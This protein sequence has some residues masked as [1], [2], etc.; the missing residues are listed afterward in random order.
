MGS[1]VTALRDHIFFRWHKHIDDLWEYW[2]KKQI[3]ELA[4]DAPPVSLQTSDVVIKK[5]DTPIDGFAE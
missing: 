5:T 1:T 3:I 4:E 2:N